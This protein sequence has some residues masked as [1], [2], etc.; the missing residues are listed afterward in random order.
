MTLRFDMFNGSCRQCDSVL[1]RIVFLLAALLAGPPSR[2]FSIVRM[3][4]LMRKLRGA[5]GFI[6]SNPKIR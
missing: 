3:N 2:L 1:E 6:R 5:E 4:P